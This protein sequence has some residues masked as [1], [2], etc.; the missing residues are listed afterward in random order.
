MSKGRIEMKRKIIRQ[1]V[2]IKK[3]MVC[4]LQCVTCFVAASSNF[5]GEVSPFAVSVL[6]ASGNNSIWCYLSALLGLWMSGNLKSCVFYVSAMTLLMG[7][8]AIFMLERRKETH[9]TS[10]FVTLGSM[11]VSLFMVAVF[12][13]LEYIQLFYYLCCSVL[14]SLIV[15]LL[16]SVCDKTISNGILDING[17][18]GASLGVL[19]VSLVSVYAGVSFWGVNLG[20]ILCVCIILCAAFKYKHIGGA[21]CGALTTCSVFLSE[22]ELAGNTMLLATSGLIAGAFSTGGSFVITIVFLITTITGLAVG[23]V[24]PDTFSMLKDVGIGCVIF[25]CLPRSFVNKLS[26]VVGGEANA[27]SIVGHAA[28]SKLS[29]ASD[30]LGSIRNQITDISETIKS[31]CHKKSIQELVGNDSCISCKLCNDCWRNNSNSTVTGFTKLEARISTVGQLTKK[32]IAEC[33][34]GCKNSDKLLNSFNSIYKERVYEQSNDIRIN[35]LREVVTSQLCAMEDVLCDLS[36]RINQMSYIDPVLSEKIKQVVHRFGVNNIRVCVFSDEKKSYRVE[37]YLTSLD[38]IDL[39]KLTVSIS[40]ILSV[41][42]ELPQIQKTESVTK[43][44][45][46]PK[47]EYELRIGYWQ[48]SANNDVYCGDTLEVI[49]IST[50][51]EYVVLS[52]GMGTGKRAKLDSLLTSNLTGKLVKAGVSCETAVRMINSILRVK[53]WEESFAT[54]DIARFDLYRGVCDIIKA[55][56]APSFLIRDEVV[57][58][59]SLDTLPLGILP[60]TDIASQRIKLFDNDILIIASDGISDF[61]EQSISSIISDKKSPCNQLAK[62]IAEAFFELSNSYKK[63]DVS[64]IV[65]KMCYTGV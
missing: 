17:L 41:Q 51:E 26:E 49:P 63:D 45:F 16:L 40:E 18:N 1:D 38:S 37:M 52:D 30:T 56:A 65:I 60:Q 54:L 39:V 23:N 50:N 42:M 2:I 12:Y 31:K 10:A 24:N 25:S 47:A 64:I 7:I 36:H 21:V 3:M 27:V 44:V 43:L 29:F 33:L 53:G 9:L 4:I 6:G 62:K 34:N 5:L 48:S 8:R 19:Y 22:P 28:S 20:R 61:D 55:G 58:K 59:I 35:E 57:S 15:Y 11:L 13:G 14:C 46:C 32:D